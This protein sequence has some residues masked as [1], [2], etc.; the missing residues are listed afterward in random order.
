MIKRVDNISEGSNWVIVDN[1]R[2][3][4]HLYLNTAGVDYPD[5]DITFFKDGFRINAYDTAAKVLSYNTQNGKYIYL[6]VYDNDN[7]SGR[8]KYTKTTDTSTL[9][10]NNAKIPFANGVDGNGSTKISTLLRNEIIP[11]LTF[12]IK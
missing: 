12:S 9:L 5:T 1:A 6:V 10:L 8:S 2:G 11:N 7:G 4:N 3:S